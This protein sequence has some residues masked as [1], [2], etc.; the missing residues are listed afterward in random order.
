MIIYL[1][2]PIDAVSKNASRGW[3]DEAQRTIQILGHTAYCPQLAWGA[4]Y[5]DSHSVCAYNRVVIR[6]S[7]GM[8]VNLRV[9]P[10]FETIREIELARTAGK[11]VMIWVGDNEY[12]KY[13]SKFG[14][15]DLII[16]S[17]RYMGAAIEHFFTLLKEG[18]NG[19]EV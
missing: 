11:P 9:G 19:K 3:A 18:S 14:C 12:D 7:Q 6:A 13:K 17:S 4:S 15:R 2:G 5:N 8:F 1:A 16:N 10:V